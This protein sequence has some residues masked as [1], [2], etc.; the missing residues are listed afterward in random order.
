MTNPSGTV[1]YTDGGASPNP[2]PG[3]WGAVILDANGRAAKELS[4]GELDSTNNRMELTA[5]IEGLRSQPAGSRI[6]L[7]TDSTYVRNGITK[8]I[9]SW[10]AKNWMR[11]PKA[12]EPVKNA[13]LWKQLH[14]LDRERHVDWRWL[15]GHAGH[16]FNE[17]ADELASAA[18]LTQGGVDGK[19]LV[20]QREADF[21]A[22]DRQVIL[23]V[24]A[25]KGNAQWIALIM[26][27]GHQQQLD[28]TETGTANRAE[29]RAGLSVLTATD[30]DLSLSFRCGD[31]FAKGCSEWLAGWKSRGWLTAGGDEVKNQDLWKLVDR[32]IAGRELAFAPLPKTGPVA[33][34]L[35]RRLK[36]LN[37]R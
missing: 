23:K 35:K 15:K 13:D 31:Y 12:N 9:K 33:S 8:W 22:A 29:L 1:I 17:R 34:D 26:D 14:Q 16:E 24:R 10:V 25:H 7:Y 21:D 20:E 30:H 36:E 37:Q 3:G 27:R 32:E 5:A 4:G 6:V 18:I 2:G 11:G 28:G 19:T